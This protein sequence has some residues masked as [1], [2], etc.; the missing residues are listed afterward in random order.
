MNRGDAYVVS[1]TDGRA[2]YGGTPSG[3]QHYGKPSI[4][5]RSEGYHVTLYPFLLMDIAPDNALPDPYGGEAQAAFPWR[6]RIT[7][8]E[9]DV[10]DQIDFFF[11][12]YRAFILH[13]MLRWQL[14]LAQMAS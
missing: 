8:V 3:Q 2:N 5:S 7:P 1:A 4:C 11:E 10:D 9:G 14:T 12:Q 6:G 13:T